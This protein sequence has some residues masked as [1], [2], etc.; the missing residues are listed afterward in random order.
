MRLRDINIC[1]HY[2]EKLFFFS[3]L[4]YSVAVQLK[5]QMFGVNGF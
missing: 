5:K 4:F 3:F 1:M 2:L